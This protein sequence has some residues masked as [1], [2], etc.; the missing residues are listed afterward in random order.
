M[1]ALLVKGVMEGVG[2]PA[3]TFC[4]FVPLFKPLMS[5][6]RMDASSSVTCRPCVTPPLGPQQEG[7]NQKWLHH[8]CLLVGPKMGGNATQPLR[9]RGPQQRGQN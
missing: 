7:Q 2:V 6:S 9:S 1:V 4:F 3:A 5:L 8:P